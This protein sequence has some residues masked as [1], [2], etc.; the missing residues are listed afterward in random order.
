TERIRTWR[1]L[2]I[3]LAE[4]EQDLGLNITDEQIAELRAHTEDINFGDAAKKER[5][6]RHDV[7]AH[8]YAYG[9]QC[10]AARGIIHL[11]A[12]SCYVTDNA[13]MIIYKKALALVRDKLVK[14]IANLAGFARE[15]ASLPCLGYTHLQVA[16]PVTVGKRA[17][18]WIQ[19]LMLDLSDIEYVMDSLKLLGSKGTTGTQASFL[20]LF[21]GDHEKCRR[22]DSL[23][24]KKMS[25]A[26]TYAVTGQT[27]PRKEDSRIVNA[28]SGIAQSAHR[29]GS[30]VRLLQ[31]MRELEEP[32]EKSQVGSSAMAYKRNPMRCERI[33]SIARYVIADALNP[34][35][36]ASTQWLER[37]LD[38]SA[39][40]RIAIPEA[41]LAVDAILS[42]I[43]N[44]TDGM[45]V[46]PAII[47][48]RLKEYLP[49]IATENLL[50]AAVKAGGDRQ[51]LHERIRVHSMEASRRMKEG[52]GV[53]DLIGRL[54][55]DPAFSMT[56]PELEALMEPSL[57]IGRAPEQV[58]EYLT[59][60]V[61]PV[62]DAHPVGNITAE[63]NI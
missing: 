61:Q 43:I 58:H 33:C 62:L 23:I 63:I 20:S 51:A 29:F 14:A 2:W 57:Y 49:F 40:R 54:A 60:E 41:F 24:A 27:Y 3:A 8:V 35:M 12:T 42:L 47:N 32:F 21:D 39:N 30:D 28:L 6:I 46:Y 17:C 56:L 31:H 37:T 13:D 34:A 15:H 5:E 45:V 7:M 16:Q 36:T 19:D 18:L 1:R 4:A 53:C 59:N 44:V 50:M 9:L 26:A 48:R 25:F 10:P 38:D 11:G 52:D 22:L 55:D